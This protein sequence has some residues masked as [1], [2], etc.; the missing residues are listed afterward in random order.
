MADAIER[1]GFEHGHD[2]DYARSAGA[3]GVSAA[4][5]PP[6]GAMPQAHQAE[7]RGRRGNGQ[8]AGTLPA[9]TFGGARQGWPETTVNGRCR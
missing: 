4:A 2:G 8:T 1:D 3:P 6:G 5:D 9:S 7:S